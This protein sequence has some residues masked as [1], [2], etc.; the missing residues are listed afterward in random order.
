MLLSILFFMLA[1]LAEISGYLVALCVTTK[2]LF[3]NRGI[4]I[5]SYMASSLPSNDW[6]W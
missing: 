3:T 1:G 5:Y 6:L 2:D 4:N